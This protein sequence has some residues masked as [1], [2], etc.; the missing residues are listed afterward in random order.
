MKT[1]YSFEPVLSDYA[2]VLILGS[3]PGTISLLKEQ[4]Y[5]HPRNAFWPIM[6]DLF[7]AF[8]SIPYLKRLNILKTHGICLWDV[9]RSCERVGSLDS[10]ISHESINNFQD[11]L[12]KRSG[13]SH[14]F[15]NGKKSKQFF[16][17]YVLPE[18]DYDH[19]EFTLLP[20]TSPAHAGMCYQEK[21]SSW[22]IIVK[23]LRDSE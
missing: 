11:L 23:T 1:L 17:F 3:M 13:I 7:G 22:R 18:L 10:S 16:E 19:L 5:S 12:Q 14:V 20:S 6:G 9:L 2:R 4:Y 8:P 15:F 21:L